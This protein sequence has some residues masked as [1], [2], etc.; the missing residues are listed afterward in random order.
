MLKQIVAT[1]LIT[2]T[3]SLLPIRAW[4][5]PGPRALINLGRA[6][7]LARQA[8]ENANGGLEH[9]RAEDSMYGPAEQSPHVYDGHG[10]WTFTFNGH[11]PDSDVPTVESIVTVS[12]SGRVEVNYNG[13][14]R[15]DTR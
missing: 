1:A 6:E 7:N 10:R 3:A 12:R 8:A 14:I 4:S 9:Y 5:Q 11:A 15:S 13:P 2:L